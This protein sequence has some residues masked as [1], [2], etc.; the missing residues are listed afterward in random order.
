LAVALPHPNG[1][2]FP[3]QPVVPVKENV[4]AVITRFG[5]TM[6]EPKVKSKKM[7]LTDPIEEEEKAEAEDQAEPR[8]KKEE[9]N[10]GKASTKD[11]SDT[12]LLPFPRQA[13]KPMKD[14]KFSRFVELIRRMYIHIPMLNAMQVLTYARYLK[15]IL[16][17]RRPI[18]KMGM[19]VFAERCSGTILDGLPD[20]MGDLGVAIIS[21]LNG[22]E[23][24]DQD[25]CDLGASVS[26]MPK[27]A[28]QSIWRPVG[29]A[30]DIS[31]RIRNSFVPVD[32]MVLEMDVCH[33]IRLFLGGHS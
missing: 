30:K 25:L 16:N 11:N 29:I 9:K 7:T 2:D 6:A 15:D 23:K 28:D 22:T 32:F 8:P 24:F 1:G 21:C 33:Q 4:K 10:L 17:Q 3:G 26:V 13:K 31:V 14:E 20:K 18:P 5:K 27:L 12:H 19:L